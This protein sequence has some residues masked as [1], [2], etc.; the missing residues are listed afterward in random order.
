MLDV[1]PNCVNKDRDPAHRPRLGNKCKEYG[2]HNEEKT[3]KEESTV[4]DTDGK[5]QN[6]GH[7]CQDDADK[8]IND[9]IDLLRVLN[10]NRREALLRGG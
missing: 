9:E 10:N 2:E 1:K 5:H 6:N 4:P 3:A 8:D 7:D